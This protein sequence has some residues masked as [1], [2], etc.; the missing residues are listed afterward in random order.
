MRGA[1]S[2]QCIRS[3]RGITLRFDF[4]KGAPVEYCTENRNRTVGAGHS[5][6][7]CACRPLPHLD[8]ASPSDFGTRRRPTGD[9][10]MAQLD[11]TLSVTTTTTNHH[12]VKYFLLIRLTNPPI[13]CKSFFFFTLNFF[14]YHPPSQSTVTGTLTLRPPLGPKPKNYTLVLVFGFLDS[15]SH[16]QFQFVRVLLRA[17]CRR[18][19]RGRGSVSPWLMSSLAHGLTQGWTA[20]LFFSFHFTSRASALLC[21]HGCSSFSWEITLLLHGTSSSPPPCS[22]RIQTHKRGVCAVATPHLKFC[23]FR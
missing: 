22:S 19:L 12:R 10:V 23:P 20:T 2:H 1:A 5:A 11:S 16:F 14:F 13:T 15:S 6:W 21:A 17:C 8:R 3:L 18:L 4:L 9:P 7:I